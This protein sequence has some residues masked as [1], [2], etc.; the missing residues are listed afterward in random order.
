MSAIRRIFCGYDAC[1]TPA[2]GN[3]LL[4]LTLHT[5][6]KLSREFPPSQNAPIKKTPT[7]PLRP[8]S[9]LAMWVNAVKQKI[10]TV[11]NFDEE[12]PCGLAC[13]N[14]NDGEMEYPM[15]CGGG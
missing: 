5:V 10:L 3:L 11:I 7:Y 15:R 2:S 4:V 12:D 13:T 1:R 6:H 14:K 8:A 9:M